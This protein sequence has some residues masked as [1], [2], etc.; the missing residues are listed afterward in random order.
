MC[1][2]YRYAE[3]NTFKDVPRIPYAVSFKLSTPIIYVY[4]AFLRSVA[5]VNEVNVVV[6]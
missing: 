6:K 3:V 5:L 4:K 2:L 1:Y